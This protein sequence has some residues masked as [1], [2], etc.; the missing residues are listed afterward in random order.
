[1]SQTALAPARGFDP[2][3]LADRPKLVKTIAVVL[4]SLLLGLLSQIEVPM[5]PVPLTLQT[6]GILLVGALYGPRLGA[7]TILVWLGEAA[8]GLPVLAGGAGGVH[9]LIGPSAGYIWSWPLMAVVVGWALQRPAL[10]RNAIAVFGTMLAACTLCLAMGGAWL[11][12]LYGVE[13]AWASGIAPFI[14]GDT[15][16]AGLATSTVVGIARLV[17]K[18]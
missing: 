6:Y 9:R 2:L 10:V 14:V 16:K 7:I 3:A 5:R 15:L 8:L 12:W 13:L 4:G 11:S 18:G 1:M 17:P